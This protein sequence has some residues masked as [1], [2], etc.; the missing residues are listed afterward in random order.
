MPVKVLNKNICIKVINFY[1]NKLKSKNIFFLNL[2]KKSINKS[3]FGILSMY[4]FEQI[5]K[6]IK[7][8]S[9]SFF[10][11]EKEEIS[12]KNVQEIIKK[13]NNEIKL[14]DNQEITISW[15]LDSPMYKWS[16]KEKRIKFFHNPFSMIKQS[17]FNST[18]KE[19]LLIKAYQYDIICNGKEIASGAI[20]NHKLEDLYSVFKRIQYE[21]KRVNR[22]FPALTKAMKFGVP[23]HGGI[24]IGIERIIMIIK[25]EYNI[26]NI[27]AFPLDQYGKSDLMR[28]PKKLFID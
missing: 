11:Y 9:Y 21:K 28:I 5:K 26:R 12:R 1:K 8:I 24:A 3:C 13:L 10:I 27:I 17:K 14:L 7:D 2:H 20:R 18:L 4:I 15:M 19:K 16:Y 25:Y 23:P 6:K 22:S